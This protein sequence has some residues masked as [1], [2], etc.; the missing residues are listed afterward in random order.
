MFQMQTN[1]NI[2]TRWATHGWMPVF[3]L[4]I[5][6]VAQSQVLI[7]PGAQ[8]NVAGGAMQLGCT[9]FLIQGTAAQGSGA[10]TTGVRN[11]MV[12]A[13]A[14][15]DMAGSS[16]QLAEQYTNNGTVSAAGG[17]L[18]RVDSAA[19]PAVGQLGPVAMSSSAHAVPMLGGVATGVLVLVMGLVGGLR[20]MRRR[21]PA[22]CLR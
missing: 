3:L 14:S 19:C 21:S 22:R 15:L 2:A 7:P 4:F 5:A 6:G 10:S 12:S 9:D 16:I 1:V 18:T 13:G 11:L 17:S 8:V 20:I